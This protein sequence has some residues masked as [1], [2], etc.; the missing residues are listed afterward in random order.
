MKLE[1]VAGRTLSGVLHVR[2]AGGWSVLSIELIDASEAETDDYLQQV[3]NYVCR[4]TLTGVDPAQDAAFT[5]L[6]IDQ[7]AQLAHLVRPSP[8][9]QPLFPSA[10]SPC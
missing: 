2:T 3:A 10:A 1:P 7:F 6:S 4:N 5:R 8:T 9:L